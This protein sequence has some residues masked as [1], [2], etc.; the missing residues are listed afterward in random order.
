MENLKDH[1]SFI[2]VLNHLKIER[3]SFVGHS[4]GGAIGYLLVTG[5]HD[6]HRIEKLILQTP[7]AST[8]ISDPL[9]FHDVVRTE[10]KTLSFDSYSNLRK[11]SFTRTEF[12][13]AGEKFIS[14]KKS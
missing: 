10:R 9:N 1:T 5:K 7:V 14:E 4:M 13:T 2:L 11:A 6:A 3:I 12:L 8:G